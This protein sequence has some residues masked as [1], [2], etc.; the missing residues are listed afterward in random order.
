MTRIIALLLIAAGLVFG[1]PAAP[2]NLQATVTEQRMAQWYY[3]G[4]GL[5]ETSFTSGPT[6]NGWQ[7]QNYNY[8]NDIS[9]GISGTATK[10]AFRGASGGGAGNFKIGLYDSGGSRLAQAT[11]TGVTT[12]AG[13]WEATISVAVTS[14]TH[15][16]MVSCADVEGDY[17]YN[18]TDTGKYHTATYAAS[19]ASTIVTTNNEPNLGYAVRVYVEESGG[20]DDYTHSGTGALALSGSNTTVLDSIVSSSGN[21]AVSGTT[22]VVLEA[23]VTTSGALTFTGSHAAALEAI[24]AVSGNLTLSGSAAVAPD[25]V[26]SSSGGF[27]LGGTGEP[28]PG[29]DLLGTGVLSLGGSVSVEFTESGDI[30]YS[31]TGNLALA[32]AASI[33]LDAITSQSGN[34]ALDGSGAIAPDFLIAGTGALSLAGSSALVPEFVLTPSGN[35]ALSGSIATEANFV[36]A[37]SGDLELGGTAVV[38]YTGPVSTQVATS[39][40]VVVPCVATVV[41]LDHRTIL[42]LQKPRTE[43]SLWK[44]IT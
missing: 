26:V 8:G 9:V 3:P 2:E 16:V 17:Y 32:G 10:I 31:G 30:V 14:G 34:L 41:K 20:G 33:V 11:I 36:V 39:T 23:I 29:F 5:G 6:T 42:L 19:M 1:Q 24:A 22:G 44:D 43:V 35:L 28:V 12:T 15:Y 40:I 13:W 37:V 38:A 21:L 7:P 27:L 18:T 25:W 4:S